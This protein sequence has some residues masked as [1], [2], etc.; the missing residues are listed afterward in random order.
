MIRQDDE[1]CSNSD[2]LGQV[3]GV[4]G[5]NIVESTDE[6]YQELNWDNGK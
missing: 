5:V 1:V 4:I 6:G 3:P 2:R